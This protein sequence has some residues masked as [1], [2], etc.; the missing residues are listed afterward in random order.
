MKH[1]IVTLLLI[2]TC[3]FFYETN[4]KAAPDSND[5][6]TIKVGEK[7]KIPHEYRV[8]WNMGEGIK[9]IDNELIGVKPGFST[10]LVRDKDD[11]FSLVKIEIQRSGI[12][13]DML[14]IGQGDAFLI[15]VNGYVILLD[16]G[17]RRYYEFLI[18]QLKSLGVNKID[19]LII[20]HMD[21]DH[22][23]AASLVINDFDIHYIL[24][25]STPGNSEEY[26]KLC[27]LIND[28]KIEC[29]YVKSGKVFSIGYGCILDILAIDMV[30][31]TNDSSIVMK[32]CYY[33]NSFLFT[34]DASSTVLN[35]IMNEGCD[36]SADVLK[37]PHHG[38]DSSSP[39]LFLK[40]TGA[41]I[42]LISVGRDNQYGHPTENVLRRLKSNK[43]A[44]YR[45]DK[46]GT[47]ILRGDGKDIDC[48]IKQIVDWNAEERLRVD[49]GPV[50]ANIN[51]RVFHHSDC[52]S[53][54]AEKNRIFFLNDKDAKTAGYRPCGNC[55][56]TFENKEQLSDRE[57]F[58]RKVIVSINKLFIV[59]REY[60][61]KNIYNN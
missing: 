32:I 15:R 30:Q 58:I 34:G 38:S 48:E 42:A 41:R 27:N 16:T 22:M 10:V 43:T 17:E 56:R 3:I 55:I 51:S 14:D 21:T 2:T 47:V 53:L 8:I 11:C 18:Q 52:M 37:I 39:I 28:N 61:K 60:E 13:V 57:G 29:R 46:D 24:S 9:H 25:P 45:T 54:P 7:I 59:G 36:I 19:L 20:S 4:A 12:E 1:I 49:M 26:N 31:D 40:E 33:D 50:I 44:V 5:T 35:K 23:G 6:I